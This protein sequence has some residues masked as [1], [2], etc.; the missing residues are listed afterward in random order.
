MFALACKFGNPTPV[1]PTRLL[2]LS[3]LVSV[4]SLASLFVETM[5][6][7]E[8]W[9][10]HGEG[11]P[12]TEPSPSKH[13]RG[14]EVVRCFDERARCLSVPSPRL[15][16]GCLE[17]GGGPHTSTL[18]L[19]LATQPW[20]PFAL[21]QKLGRLRRLNK[22]GCNLRCLR[23]LPEWSSKVVGTASAC[24]SRDSSGICFCPEAVWLCSAW[25][26]FDV[27][28]CGKAAAPSTIK[29]DL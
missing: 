25:S 11:T 7:F 18:E 1:Q 26:P 16:R 15:A 21:Q 17:T 14:L 12:A 29:G 28:T 2:L 23:S 19:K 9:S 3:G 5:R 27:C 22:T 8:L 6:C 24:S 13:Q 20:L 4:E 10:S